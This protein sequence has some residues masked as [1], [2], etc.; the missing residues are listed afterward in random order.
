MKAWFRKFAE[1]QQDTSD[2]ARSGRPPAIN[3]QQVLAAIEAEPTLITRMLTVDLHCSHMQIARILHK[4]G[5]KIRHGK[6]VPHE[7]TQ[8]NK[9]DR[10]A[11]AQQLL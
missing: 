6:W 7:L 9:N 2:R 3:D 5:K 8:R 11:A 10:L 1:G 4:A